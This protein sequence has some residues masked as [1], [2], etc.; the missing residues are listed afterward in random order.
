MG[1]LCNN[2]SNDN[3]D[4]NKNNIVY[5]ST[6]PFIPFTKHYI[7]LSNIPTTSP[8]SIVKETPSYYQDNTINISPNYS[9]SN[10][11]SNSYQPSLPNVTHHN[12][13]NNNNNMT[14]FS[15]ESILVSELDLFDELDFLDELDLPSG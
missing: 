11:L 6:P 1:N 12:I 13:N 9:L 5:I 3:P 4:K 14:N 2:F 15:L 8:I 10:S 7:D